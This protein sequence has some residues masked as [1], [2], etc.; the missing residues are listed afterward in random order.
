MGAQVDTV[1]GRRPRLRFPRGC[2]RQGVPAAAPVGR[3]LSALKHSDAHQ[4]RSS[5]RPRA[6]SSSSLRSLLLSRRA[7]GSTSAYLPRSWIRVRAVVPLSSSAA[8]ISAGVTC[9]S[10]TSSMPFS[11]SSCT[12]Q[13]RVGFEQHTIASI[14]KSGR[15]FRSATHRRTPPS[16][17]APTSTITAIAWATSSAHASVQAS[18]RIYSGDSVQKSRPGPKVDR[19]PA[20][21]AGISASATSNRS[22]GWP[23]VILAYRS[24][25]G[26]SPFGRAVIHDVPRTRVK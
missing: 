23:D 7:A 21:R 12:C 25:A 15:F 22:V 18:A 3:V 17:S 13:A 11:M 6:T 26:T 14:R 2:S 4:A 19:W 24:P 10:R 20:G 9:A 16:G 1:R 5:D 8:T